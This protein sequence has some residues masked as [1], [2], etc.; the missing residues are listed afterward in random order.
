[1]QNEKCKQQPTPARFP[2]DFCGAASA[3]NRYPTEMS[4]VEWHACSI[5]V[6]LVMTE[7]LD[8]LIERIVAAYSALQLIPE[9]EQAEFRYELTLAIMNTCFSHNEPEIALEAVR[10]I[11]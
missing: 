4:G 2:C 7:K 1:M 9:D 6:A 3:F 8:L 11:H 5:C 10:M